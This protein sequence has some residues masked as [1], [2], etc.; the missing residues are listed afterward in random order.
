MQNPYAF[1]NHIKILFTPR[2]L[3]G[4]LWEALS[5]A[6]Q[7]AY[8]IKQKWEKDQTSLDKQREENKERKNKTN[9]YKNNE[10]LWDI[11]QRWRVCIK[12]EFFKKL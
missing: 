7:G 10:C 4:P 12:K 11:K 8:R 2:D 6:L 5:Y 3:Y 9:L 1:I